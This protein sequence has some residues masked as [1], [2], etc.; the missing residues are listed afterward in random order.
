MDAAQYMVT[1]GHIVL[2]SLLLFGT[3][4]YML[5][6][7]TNRTRVRRVILTW[8]TRWFCRRLCVPAAFTLLVFG[9]M[10]Y[11][12]WTSQLFHPALYGGY[13][14]SGIFWSVGAFLQ[15]LVV[16]SDYGIVQDIN[17]R[18]GAIAW[19]QVGD[20]FVQKE[21]GSKQYVFLCQNREGQWQRASL[22]VPEAYLDCFEEVIHR[23]LDARFNFTVE[24]V[25]GKEAFD[26]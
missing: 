21:E 13:L 22:R 23:K 8:R 25:Y 19:G 11:G 14:A 26:W 4:L 12:Y 24:R 10:V 6:T 5:V 18:Q 15:Q 3:S 7:L 20:Y 1:I 17:R 16:V 9:A 2:L